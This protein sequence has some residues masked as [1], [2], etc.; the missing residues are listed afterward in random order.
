MSSKS[1][2]SSSKNGQNEKQSLLSAQ[3]EEEEKVEFYSESGNTSDSKQ[4]DMFQEGNHCR[5]HMPSSSP[6]KSLKPG[7][8]QMGTNMFL[9]K[10]ICS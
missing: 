4:S 1:E 10:Q 2:E 5:V 7:K 8:H 3:Q 9:L 6:S